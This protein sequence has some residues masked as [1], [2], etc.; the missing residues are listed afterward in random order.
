MPFFLPSLKRHGYLDSVDL[1]ICNVGSRKYSYGDD[2]GKEKGWG[3]FAPNLTIIGFDADE[4]ACEAA[5]A[6]FESR[7]E[8]WNEF[9]FP[10]A[11]AENAG[12]ATLHMTKAPMCSSLY[13]PND[14]FLRR[15][16]RL[17]PLVTTDHTIELD[18]I[19]L[20]EFCQ[21]EEIKIIDFLQVDVQ[22]A[23][24][25]V[26]SGAA[27]IL[28]NGVLAV[29]VE[30]EFS[31]LYTG[32]PLFADVDTFMRSKGFSLFD[33]ES[34]SRESRCAELVSTRRPGQ[35]LWADA[36]YLRD[37]LLL[38]DVSAFS[39]PDQLFKLACVADVLEFMDYSLELLEYLT[40]QYGK[41]NPQY[42]Y[43]N[44]IMESLGQ[45]PELVEFGAEKIP[46]ALRLK[47]YLN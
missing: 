26:L 28:D 9:H 4:A 1:T 39:Q 31:S 24:L 32:Q 11:I 36:I 8:N 2:Y 33:L 22:G 41:E 45:I 19:S 3:I 20:D 38:K 43:A 7:G 15:F 6:E 14:E 13:P 21:S 17:P 42:N 12:R 25:H 46:I 29:Q 47:D 10:Y 16:P 23:D 44:A 37:P 30:V 40:T 34:I 27:G 18:T 35:L 5:N